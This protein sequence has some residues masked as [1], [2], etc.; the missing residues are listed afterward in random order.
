MGFLRVT[1]TSEKTAAHVVR[2]HDHPA[3]HVI[4]GGGT[5]SEILRQEFDRLLGIF[6]QPFVGTVEKLSAS[7]VERA[8]GSDSDF[9][10]TEHQLCTTSI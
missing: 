10:L 5:L 4:R 7:D 1:R 3:Q 9:F 6:R 2:S 8:I